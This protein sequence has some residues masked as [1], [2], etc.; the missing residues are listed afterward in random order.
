[1]S[2]V[3]FCK[4]LVSLFTSSRCLTE[5]QLLNFCFSFS[6]S[7][8]LAL[9]LAGATFKYVFF[10]DSS[11]FQRHLNQKYK[12]IEFSLLMVGCSVLFS[13]HQN[14][15]NQAIVLNLASV[16]WMALRTDFANALLTGAVAFSPILLP[17]QAD[18]GKIVLLASFVYPS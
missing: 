16:R 2:E 10:V 9:L 8:N 18:A 14:K 15:L 17:F 3:F 6:S 7:S 12:A 1:M 11:P 13:R 5:S 4:L